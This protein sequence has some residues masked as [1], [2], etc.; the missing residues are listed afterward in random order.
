[1]KTNGT[2]RKRAVEPPVDS[3]ETKPRRRGK[4]AP[5][6]LYRKTD[7]T[8]EDIFKAL[9]DLPRLRDEAAAEIERLID[10]LDKTDCVEA[11]TTDPRWID[12]FGDRVLLELSELDEA[13]D[14]EPCDSENDDRELDDCELEDGN[15]DEPSLGSL[16]SGN[17]PQ[18]GWAALCDGPLDAEEEH[19]GREP[20]L[21]GVTAGGP[22]FDDK[23]LEESCEDEGELD[24]GVGDF[25]GL[26][27]Q[28]PKQFDHTDIGV[29]A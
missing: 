27:E 28:W 10:F 13:V 17:A 18:T 2:A 4:A 6:P 15:D 14:D 19:D 9:G 12:R 22:L 23:D 11:T 1:M 24:S 25:D 29:M 20:S 21:C 3:G 5:G 26:M 7:L 8:P 16:G